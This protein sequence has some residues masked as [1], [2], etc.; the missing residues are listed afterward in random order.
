MIRAVE[1]ASYSRGCPPFALVGL[2]QVRA[3]PPRDYRCRPAWAR[4]DDLGPA[5]YRSLHAPGIVCAFVG[6]CVLLACMQRHRHALAPA[7]AFE[8]GRRAVQGRFSGV[9]NCEIGSRI[10]AVPD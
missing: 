5:K 10:D 1:K 4:A 2:N 6:A 7:Y 9:N 3:A 8:V